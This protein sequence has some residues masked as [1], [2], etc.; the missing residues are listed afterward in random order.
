[1][2]YDLRGAE[3]IQPPIGINGA[4]GAEGLHHGLLAGLGVVNVV[5]DY[6]AGRKHCVDVTG[7][8]LLYTSRC[9]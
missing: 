5:N 4:V 6:I 1:M 9:V 8:C 7:S 2:E 3:H